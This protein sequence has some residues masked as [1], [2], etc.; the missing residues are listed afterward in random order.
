MLAMGYNCEGAVICEVEVWLD[1]GLEI[2]GWSGHEWSRHE[3]ET[4][5]HT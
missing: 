5:T 1:I 3:C 4:T 2:E